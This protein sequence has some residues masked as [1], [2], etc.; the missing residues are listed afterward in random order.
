MANFLLISTAGVFNKSKQQKNAGLFPSSSAD[1]F[2]SVPTISQTRCYGTFFCTGSR[3]YTLPFLRSQLSVKEAC[4]PVPPKIMQNKNNNAS[5]ANGIKRK[6]GKRWDVPLGPIGLCSLSQWNFS[7]LITFT[8]I[9]LGADFPCRPVENLMTLLNV[10]SSDFLVI[11]VTV[12]RFLPLF[13]TWLKP[14]A[15][16]TTSVTSPLPKVS[17]FQRLRWMYFSTQPLSKL[18]SKGC[19]LSELGRECAWH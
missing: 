19:I 14:H 9:L 17:F 18:F 12:F 1:G 10:F 2:N 13:I 5:P 3:R 8:D 16:V 11:L 4:N 15:T 6:Q 7:A